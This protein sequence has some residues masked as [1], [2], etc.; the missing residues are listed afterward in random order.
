MTYGS[1][2]IPGPGIDGYAKGGYYNA[3]NGGQEP[4]DGTKTG[5]S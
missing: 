5:L 4:G 3:S 1:F 2:M